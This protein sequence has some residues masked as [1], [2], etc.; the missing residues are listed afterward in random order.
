MK[1]YENAAQQRILLR[2]EQQDVAEV[3]VINAMA[4]NKLE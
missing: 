1:E 2:Q 3:V 4:T